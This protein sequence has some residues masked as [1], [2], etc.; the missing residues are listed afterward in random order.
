MRALSLVAIAALTFALALS[1]AGPTLAQEQPI[2]SPIPA[3]MAKI[4]AEKLPTAERY[5]CYTAYPENLAI[6][7]QN[8]AA[9][10]RRL[11]QRADNVPE[12]VISKWQRWRD[13][14]AE[15]LAGHKENYAGRCLQ[16]EAPKE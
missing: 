3:G 9:A 7:Q 1:L 13:N 11:D 2:P 10:E 8:L 6:L 12:D 4:Q 5:F 16:D 15:R 14:A